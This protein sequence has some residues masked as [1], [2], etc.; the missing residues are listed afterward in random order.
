MAVSAGLEEW[1]YLKARKEW[2]YLQVRK[3][4]PYLQVRKEFPY[5]QVWKSDQTC[6]LG[7]VVAPA[8]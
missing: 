2:P 3:K 4:W 7:R 5:L 6:R 8:G 1:P